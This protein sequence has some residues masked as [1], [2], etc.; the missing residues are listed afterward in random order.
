MHSAKG[1]HKDISKH[2]NNKNMF[3]GKRNKNTN[4][5]I[6]ERVRFVPSTPCHELRAKNET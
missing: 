1:K 4:R 3:S 2:N 5:T 6:E